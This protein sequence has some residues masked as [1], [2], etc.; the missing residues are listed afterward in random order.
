MLV[1]IVVLTVASRLIIVIFRYEPVPHAC[2]VV[3]KA[4]EEVGRRDRAVEEAEERL[5]E[6]Q[7][8]LAAGS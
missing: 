5:R 7:E 8:A 1:D 2:Q 6:A 4:E 3:G